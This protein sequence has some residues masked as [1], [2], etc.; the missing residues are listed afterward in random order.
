MRPE[1]DVYAVKNR[2][3]SVFNNIYIRFRRRGYPSS[4]EGGDGQ[5]RLFITFATQTNHE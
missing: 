4:G 1:T 2:Y 3:T 5:V